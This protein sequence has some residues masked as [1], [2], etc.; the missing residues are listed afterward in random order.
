[1]TQVNSDTYQYNSGGN[2]VL[3]DAAHGDSRSYGY[4]AFNLPTSITLTNSGNPNPNQYSFEYDAYQHRASKQFPTGDGVTYAGKL[5]Q[6]RVQS[7]Q[8][9][10]VFSVPS[11]HGRI[12]A[13]IERAAGASGNVIHY[14]HDDSL[15][16]VQVTTSQ[17]GKTEEQLWYEPFGQTVEPDNPGLPVAPTLATITEGFTAQ[18]EDLELKLVDMV[19]RIYDP[20][21]GRFLTPDPLIQNFSSN[22]SLDRYTY[23]RNNPFKWIDPS[24]FQGSDPSDGS[25]CDQDCSS[26]NNGES[27]APSGGNVSTIY[28]QSSDW[29]G[30]IEVGLSP[31]VSDNGAV[32]PSPDAVPLSGW[33]ALAGPGTQTVSEPAKE[34]VDW[35]SGSDLAWLSGGLV[36]SPGAAKDFGAEMQHATAYLPNEVY[37]IA[38]YEGFAVHPMKMEGALIAGVTDRGPNYV[39]D[40]YVGTIAGTG[41]GVEVPG[42]DGEPLAG[43]SWMGLR[44][45]I[46]WSGSGADEPTA[47]LNV[48]DGE[49]G[50]YGGGV[51]KT[52]DETEAGAYVYRSWGEFYLGMGAGWCK[53]G[54]CEMPPPRAP[55]VSSGGP[56]FIL[57]LLSG[58]VVLPFFGGP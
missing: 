24:G 21:T 38:G 54:V 7:G 20:Q 14:L 35:W 13:Q 27:N 31:T 29:A 26:N 6:R 44:E 17:A 48:L 58:N 39:L 32:F 8:V 36:M 25:S 19:G 18:R 2:Q 57:N 23:A 45:D 28:L 46:W 53:G 37:G 47:H 4:S 16:S 3:W 41:L 55:S 49:I 15:G 30:T 50:D 51:W 34:S 52:D 9:T 56:S 12:V 40:P 33:Q 1:V 5:Y 11:A 10:E 42:L 22:E 43:A